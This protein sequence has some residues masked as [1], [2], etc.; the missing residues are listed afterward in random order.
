MIGKGSVIKPGNEATIFSIGAITVTALEAAEILEK[1]NIST[2]VIHI[3]SLKPLDKEMIASVAG[4]RKAIV[5][6]EEHTTCG[7][8]GSA[9]AEIVAESGTGVPFKMI[10]V[11]DVFLPCIG[12]QDYL[13]QK[14]GLS[15]ANIVDAI[16]KIW[17]N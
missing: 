11:N 17:K 3:H 5:T 8:L 12:T 10:G 9:I 15:G 6:L 4:S 16:K 13:R 1:N 2:E 14:A 7:G